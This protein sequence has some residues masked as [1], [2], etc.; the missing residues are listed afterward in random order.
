MKEKKVQPC[1]ENQNNVIT[2]RGN[3]GRKK[4]LEGGGKS[5]IQTLQNPR[6]QTTPERR[7]GKW[8]V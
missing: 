1:V 7:G 4:G 8:V 5:L 3:R 6:D 2:V